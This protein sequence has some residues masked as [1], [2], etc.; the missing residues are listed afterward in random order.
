MSRTIAVT[1]DEKL[2]HVEALSILSPGKRNQGK[3]K[4]ETGSIE[5]DVA[6]A[7]TT[8]ATTDDAQEVEEEEIE[9]VE[10]DDDDDDDDDDDNGGLQGGR[11]E[12]GQLRL[13]D[14]EKGVIEFKDGE[15]YDNDGGG[16]VHLSNAVKARAR[17]Q[18]AEKANVDEVE[19][20][21]EED[22]EEE[23]K[24]K[25]DRQAKRLEAQ[26]SGMAEGG[27]EARDASNTSAASGASAYGYGDS[28][29]EDEE[30]EDDFEVAAGGGETKGKGSQSPPSSSSS[31]SS[32]SPSPSSRSSTAAKTTATTTNIHLYGKIDDGRRVAF[33]PDVVSEV[34]VSRE[35]YTRQEVLE[36][37][38]THEEALQFSS[39]YYKEMYKVTHTPQHSTHTLTH[40]T[41]TH[42]HTHPHPH[43]HT[44]T[45]TC[46]KGR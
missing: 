34:I 42:T 38:Y 7:A 16:F 5:V 17:G 4:S 46:I 37:F 32:S 15:D 45:H 36:L 3:S 31:S 33:I 41:H 29:E 40:Y 11:G 12:K 20:F 23:E 8:T 2:E 14:R 22:D 26:N 35:K 19:Q 24:K 30:Y 27:E 6:V 1:D 18:E 25:R 13:V 39:D 44:N 9:E 28:F 21:Y 10:E 43:A